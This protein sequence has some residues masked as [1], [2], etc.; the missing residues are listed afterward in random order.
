MDTEKCDHCS[1]PLTEGKCR[2]FDMP[3]SGG[4]PYPESIVVCLKPECISWAEA[5]SADAWSDAE[6]ADDDD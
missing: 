1:E 5:V 3:M 6:E 2:E 4:N